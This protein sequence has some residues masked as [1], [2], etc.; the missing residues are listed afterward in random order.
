MSFAKK[1]YARLEES[2][3]RLKNEVEVKRA[4]EQR[5]KSMS[6][7]SSRAYRSLTV[8][9]DLLDRTEA[10]DEESLNLKKQS[11]E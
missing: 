7:F 6:H 11:R 1:E 3:A 2:I 10:L 4:E 9:L 5:A 8:S